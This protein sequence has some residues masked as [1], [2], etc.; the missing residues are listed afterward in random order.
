[1]VNV[2][3]PLTVHPITFD[4]HCT[5]RPI[6]FYWATSAMASPMMGPLWECSVDI[7]YRGSIASGCQRRESRRRHRKTIRTMIVTAI[8][9]QGNYV[10]SPTERIDL[11]D[12]RAEQIS[13][14]Q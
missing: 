2:A 5:P 6:D 4:I 13:V 1:V 9:I 11:G 12:G 10:I 3:R 14:H 8:N 7:I